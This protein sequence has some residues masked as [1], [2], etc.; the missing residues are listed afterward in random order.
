MTVPGDS[1]R[2]G[3][4]RPYDLFWCDACNFGQLDPRPSQAEVDGFYTIDYHTHTVSGTA[5]K[6]PVNHAL[7]ER[8]RQR[9]AWSFDRGRDLDADLVHEL[10]RHRPSSICD[11][12]CGNGG[13]LAD[14]RD[15]GHRVVGL[16]P[17]PVARRLAVAR[18][19]DVHEGH[20]DD[21]PAAITS[22]RFDVAVLCHVLLLC[23][24]PVR[25]L[26][27]VRKILR[28]GGLFVCE[29][30]NN[31]ALGLRQSGACWRWLD[32][33]RHLNLF[34]A[35][36]LRRICAGAGLEVRRIDFVGYTRQFKRV[37]LDDEARKRAALYPSRPASRAWQSLQ[38]WKLLARTA[39]ARS[40]RKY[41]SVRIVAEAG[42]R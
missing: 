21:P 31:E 38:S 7:L 16:E 11:L 40:E 27:G 28:P 19:L 36:S 34:T 39:L 24:D 17:D 9:M 25:V 42:G 22:D 3:D 29:T 12:G 13:L 15:R 2:P 33:P 32:I 4:R 6:E 37:W 1:H 26:Q 14:L 41:D 8:L 18:G 35:A 10:V 23:L 30:P 5:G 20:A